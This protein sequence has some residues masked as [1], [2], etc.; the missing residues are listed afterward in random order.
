[1]RS[2]IWAIVVCQQNYWRLYI[3]V[4]ILRRWPLCFRFCSAF[5]V[6]CRSVKTHPGLWLIQN[7]ISLVKYV[8][9]KS[10]AVNVPVRLHGVTQGDLPFRWVHVSLGTFSRAEFKWMFIQHGLWFTEYHWSW[11]LIA[12][13]CLATCCNVDWLP[14]NWY[15]NQH[16]NY[17]YFTK[18]LSFGESFS[19][20]W[21][22]T[23]SFCLV[24]EMTCVE[25]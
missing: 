10:V 5:S 9:L 13:K 25:K 15:M 23:W 16:K 19:L 11:S 24:R 2:L 14:S 6:S 18:I 20:I 1:M 4:V 7:A 17:L 3:I 21:L 8:I 22:I 12:V